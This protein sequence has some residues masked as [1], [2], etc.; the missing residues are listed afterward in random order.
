MKKINL[1]FAVFMLG[2][3]SLFAQ[4]NQD[5]ETPS[6]NKLFYVELGG[7]GVIMS[8]NYDMRFNPNSRLGL[9]VRVGAGFGVAEFDKNTGRQYHYENYYDGGYYNNV[10]THSYYSFP[11]QINYVFGREHSASTFEIGGGASFLTRKVSLYNYDSTQEG[12]VIGGLSFMYR[13]QPVRGGFSLRVGFTPIIGTAG[14]L[15]PM[16]GISLGYAF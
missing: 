12:H 9:G 7:P 15:F 14:D 11:V 6:N 13:L 1:F 8:M 4:T 2:F 16:G 3:T 10:E 5:V